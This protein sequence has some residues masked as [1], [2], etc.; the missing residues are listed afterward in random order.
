[1]H[2]RDLRLQVPYQPAVGNSGFVA[3][4]PFSLASSLVPRARLK[5]ARP[6]KSDANL[7]ISIALA[8]A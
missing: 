8:N 2:G 6:G 1:M 4:R 7:L 5:F 3:N